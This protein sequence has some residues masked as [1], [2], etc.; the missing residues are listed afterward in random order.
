MKTIYYCQCG[1][2]TTPRNWR[3]EGWLKVDMRYT[4]GNRWK[5]YVCP[6]CRVK[7]S[8]SQQI[9]TPDPLRSDHALP[10]LPNP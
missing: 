10:T 9:P 5:T 8:M 1:A 6:V 2:K 4:D 7:K 3:T